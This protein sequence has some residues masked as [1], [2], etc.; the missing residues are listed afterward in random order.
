MVSHSNLG[1]K[2]LHVRQVKGDSGSVQQNS[3]HGNNVILRGG[4]SISDLSIARAFCGIDKA[5][6]CPSGV[7]GD[8]AMRS[9]G[10]LF[11]ACGILQGYK[12]RGNNA[13]DGGQRPFPSGRIAKNIAFF[14]G[15]LRDLQMPFCFSPRAHLKERPY[16]LLVVSPAR[17]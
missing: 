5:A 3:D 10:A 4:D 1:V 11:A 16:F 9:N 7:S 6:W 17:R 8:D 13:S 14:D 12:L 2:Y 15:L